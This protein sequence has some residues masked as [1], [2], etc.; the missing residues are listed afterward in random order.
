M[1]V[2]VLE[3]IRIILTDQAYEHEVKYDKF[4]RLKKNKIKL[5]LFSFIVESK[6]K[7]Y[8]RTLLFI[9]VYL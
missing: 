7:V 2:C 1:N 4:Y 8:K 3:C 9:S 6:L 5:I